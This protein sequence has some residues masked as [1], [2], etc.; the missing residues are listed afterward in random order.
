MTI[1]VWKI[2]RL[3]KFSVKFSRCLYFC[4]IN[5]NQSSTF[6]FSLH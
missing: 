4:Q 1:K 5:L 2:K 3:R 6:V